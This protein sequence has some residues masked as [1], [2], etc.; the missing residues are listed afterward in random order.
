MAIWKTYRISEIITEIAEEKFVLP[1]IQRS[2]VWTEDK[3]ELLF[4][5]LLKGDSFGGIMVIEEEKGDEPLF[6]FRPFTKDGSPIPA[7]QVSILTQPQS[8]VIDGQ[9]RLQAFYMGLSGSFDGKVLY[10]DLYSDYKA[11]FEFK[12]EN[13]VKNLPG[14]S[15]D[16]SDRVIPEHNWHLV[17]GLLKRLKQTNDEEQV[18]SEIVSKQGIV[19][20]LQKA[21]IARNI[22]AFFRNIIV[23]ETLGISRVTL[24]R[25][26]D[27]TANR[28][29][30]VE[31]FRRLNDG[32]TKLSPFDLVASV[33]KGFEWEMEEFLRETLEIY[34]EIG[35]SQDNLIKLIFILQDNHNKEISSIEKADAAFAIDNRERIKCTLKSLKDF[36][37]H[38]KVYD[39]YKDGS[40]SFVPL[41]FVAYHIYHQKIDDNG[42]LSYFNNYDTGNTDF[43]KIKEWLFHSLL[44]GVFRSKGAGWIPYKTGVRKILEE[45]KQH[46]GKSFPIDELIKVY[47]NH[48]IAFTTEYTTDDL[49]KLDSSFVYY[50]MYDKAKTIRT[51]DIDHIMP[52]S[53]LNS[54]QYDP[55]KIN[56]IKNFQLLDPGTNRGAKNGKS[57][58][59]WINNP[60]YVTDKPA[61]LKLHL[62]PPNAAIWTED[63][64][65]DFIAARANLI[66]A[67]LEEHTA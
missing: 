32:G 62:I 67:K 29:R 30:I 39:Y 26:F 60:E 35:L 33:L 57:F 23:S 53:I 59:S 42:V 38:A 11:E 20:D 19:D 18:S 25:S 51:N 63:K 54:H 45:I 64:F 43:V 16:N 2:L 17:S 37:I 13:D 1:V 9:Q 14:K 46:K 10:F 55:L 31:L 61:F 34:E 27:D 7:R 21:H 22:R 47:T 5:T 28:Q 24:N 36:L 56:S 52:K 12:F 66:L 41:F 15:K 49:D 4:D 40:R 6:S 8:F 50:L 58:D 44:N 3:I 65:E 48:P